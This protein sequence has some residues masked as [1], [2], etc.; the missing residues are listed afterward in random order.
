MTQGDPLLLAIF[1]VV[2]DAVV[3]HLESLVSEILGGGEEAEKKTTMKR[4]S[5]R[6]GQFEQETTENGGH[7]RAIC[8]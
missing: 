6:E 1:N 5:C 2:V 7:R 4:H 8:G 3:R